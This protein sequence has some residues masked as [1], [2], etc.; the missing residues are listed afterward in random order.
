MIPDETEP[1]QAPLCVRKPPQKT[2]G[3]H[4]PMPRGEPF[5]PQMKTYFEKLKDPRWQRKR[6]E[7]MQRDGF[8]CL[9]CGDD[10]SQLAV[11]HR[12][13]LAGRM[14]WEYPSWCFRTLCG[15]CHNGEH[16]MEA[17]REE[18]EP[19]ETFIPNQDDF[20][21]VWEFLGGGKP[22]EH[23]LWDVGAEIGMIASAVGHWKAMGLVMAALTEIRKELA[24]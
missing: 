14:P 16:S 4:L 3:D 19:S 1:N 2:G 17:A 22:S 11:H 23:M 5:G 15:R 24:Q 6:L 10:K 8:A 21:M 12:Y 18:H 20:E 13:Y 9:S 7:I